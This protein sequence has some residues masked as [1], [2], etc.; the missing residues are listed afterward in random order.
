MCQR[1]N[2]VIIYD[3][4]NKLYIN[5]LKSANDIYKQF[6]HSYTFN[7]MDKAINF[8]YDDIF[9]KQNLIYNYKTYN[10]NILIDYQHINN[11]CQ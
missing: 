5:I 2:I 6:N 8:I 10:K 7:D 11:L 3:E 4:I 9:Y 1:Y